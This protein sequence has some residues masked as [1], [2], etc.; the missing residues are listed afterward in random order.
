MDVHV[1]CRIV[2]NSMDGWMIMAFDVFLM[3][4]CNV[5]FSIVNFVLMILSFSSNWI[6]ICVFVSSS[7]SYVLIVALNLLGLS[8][9]EKGG[10][11]LL[12]GSVFPVRCQTSFYKHLMT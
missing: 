3:R 6:L 12:L 11:A 2:F 8:F 5:L 9:L 1:F 4:S 7:S 10:K